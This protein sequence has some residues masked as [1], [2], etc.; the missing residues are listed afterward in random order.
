MGGTALWMLLATTLSAQTSEQSLNEMSLP[1][2]STQAAS[3]TPAGGTTTTAGDNLGNHIATEPVQ[4][5]FGAVISNGSSLAINGNGNIVMSG[6]GGIMMN[7]GKLS[8]M[9]QPT[10]GNDA[11]TKTYV[12]N[13]ILASTA[14]ADNLGNHVATMSINL[15]NNRITNLATPSLGTDAVNRNYVNSAIA[16]ITGDNLGSHLATQDLNLDNFRL[17]NL[18]VPQV[19]TDAVNKI[20]VDQK[21]AAGAST[22]PVG[23]ILPG[24][25]ISGGGKLDQDR[26][27]SFDTGFGDN[28]YVVRSRTISA[29][30]GLTGGGSLGGNISFSVD[31]SVV[32]TTGVQTIAG[33]KS[34]TSNISLGN[35]RIVNLADP[36]VGSDGVSLNYLNQRIAAL[37]NG[38][39]GGGNADNMGN[40][41]AAF[42]LNMSNFKITNLATPTTAGDATSKAYVDAAITGVA[43]SADNLGNHNATIRLNMAGQRIIG[44]ANP[45]ASTDAVNRAW[46]DGLVVTAGDGISGGGALNTDRAFA[47]D[48]TVVRTSGNQTLNGTKTFGSMVVAPAFNATS[49]TGGSFQGAA[50]DSAATPGFTWTGDTN[51]GM[52]RVAADDIGFSTNGAVRMRVRATDTYFYTPVNLG[53]NKIVGLGLPTLSTDA[54]TKGYVDS[55]IGSASGDNLGNHRMSADLQDNSGRSVIDGNGSWHR[56]YGNAGWYNGTYGGGWYMTDTTWLRAYNNKSIY[57]AGTIQAATFNAT[58]QTN[59][60]FQGIDSDNAATPSFTWSNDQNTGIY[61]AGENVIGF[62]AAGGSRATIS[63]S[64]AVFSVPIVADSDTITIR[65]NGNKYLWYREQ[66][67]TARAVSYFNDTYGGSG[68]L[69]HQVYNSGGAY[70][71]ALALRVSGEIETRG[72][73]FFTGDGKGLD[74]MNADGIVRGTLNENRLPD[75]YRRRQAGQGGEG[76]VAYSGTTRN[77]GFFYGGGTD[78]NNTG[79]RLNYNGQLWATRFYSQIYLYHSDA[80][81]KHNIVELEDGQ[82]KGILDLRPVTFTWNNNGDQAMGF[83]A[84]DIE[85]VFPLMVKTDDRGMKSVD[86][87]QMI[88]PLVKTIQEMDAR[89]KELEAAQ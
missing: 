65:S 47:V 78:P 13:A 79:Y 10:L 55:Q 63:N 76:F 57:T 26:T 17:T 83:I 44:V 37:P 36:V 80:R 21:V 67:N 40:Q 38:G 20:Y 16:A 8:G 19:D 9:G 48:G 66:N 62:A 73:A 24:P 2:F 4:L 32:R 77:N 1:T 82:T 35:N 69:I 28:R 72:N 61:R 84:Q 18:P 52:Y 42:N 7:G 56:S 75:N 29:A 64:E 6:T 25:G 60:G 70:T 33:A 34:F 71:G 15:G 81:L 43:T 45:A 51:T 27:I 53:N 31:A 88:S 68:A 12:D 50:A 74:N 23:S 22:N 11:T 86:Y 14:G 41:I 39:G 49:A 58:S 46:V 89:I 85:T 59:G 30:D 3:A 5:G 87:A 54:A